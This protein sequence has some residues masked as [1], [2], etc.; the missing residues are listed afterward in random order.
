MTTT[1]TPSEIA[2]AEVRAELARQRIPQSA[3]A[4]VLKMSEVSISRRLRGETPFD[5]NELV[6]VAEFLNLPIT[7]FLPTADHA[8]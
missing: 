7:R 6:A 3:L 8:A 5:V 2:A 4:Y 1:Q